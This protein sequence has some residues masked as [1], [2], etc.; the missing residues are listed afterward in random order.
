MPP[1]A[2]LNLA[3]V[4]AVSSFPEVPSMR[5]MVWL[6]AF[7]LLLPFSAANAEVKPHA[8]C[9]EGMVLQQ[10]SKAAIWGTA[11]AGEEVT[12]SFRGSNASAAA[13]K[14][15]KWSVKI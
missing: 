4:H 10:K 13:D 7:A 8:L 2:S 6:S 1:A 3:S 9:A 12:V 5:R 14:D 11:K 15:G